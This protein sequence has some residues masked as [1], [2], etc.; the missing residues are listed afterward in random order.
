MPCLVRASSIR[1][2]EYPI[3]K[4]KEGSSRGLQ[5]I[6]L[7]AR[8]PRGTQKECINPLWENRVLSTSAVCFIC[9]DIFELKRSRSGNIAPKSTENS[10]R[11]WEAGSNRY[12]VANP[13]MKPAVAWVEYRI[14]C[15]VFQ[16]Y[17]RVSMLCYP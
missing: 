9:F 7:R 17:L 1:W 15:E 4:P 12:R 2:I 14:L 6:K 16:A 10:K 11:I 8:M 5:H 3:K 13:A